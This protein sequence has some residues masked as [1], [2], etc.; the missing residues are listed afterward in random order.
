M[1]GD[2]LLPLGAVNQIVQVVG[3]VFDIKKFFNGS[4]FELGESLGPYGVCLSRGH[5][6]PI[7]ERP[8]R[9]GLEPSSPNGPG[10]EDVVK[11]LGLNRPHRVTTTCRTFIVFLDD[12]LPFRLLLSFKKWVERTAFETSWMVDFCDIE[13]GGQ[14]VEC[15]DHVLGVMGSW[16]NLFWPADDPGGSRAVVIETGFRKGEGHAVVGE[17]DDDGPIGLTGIIQGPQ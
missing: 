9:G 7:R 13:K 1:G 4:S 6:F 16:F 2:L 10:V 17:K 14:E 12:E 11:A 5:Q 15:R 8:L 3:I